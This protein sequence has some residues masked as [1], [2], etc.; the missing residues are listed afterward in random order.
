MEPHQAESQF[1]ALVDCQQKADV[2]DQLSSLF[3]DAHMGP[4]STSAAASGS[5]GSG[6]GGGSSATSSSKSL[7][8]CAHSLAQISRVLKRIEQHSLK[9]DRAAFSCHGS[10]VALEWR[11]ISIV[12]DRVFFT[13]FLVIICASLV[14]LFPRPTEI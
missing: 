9:H 10:D 1:H 13:V 12:L 6:D 5:G 11:Q 2:N 14:L 3:L 7:E 4:Q 8:D